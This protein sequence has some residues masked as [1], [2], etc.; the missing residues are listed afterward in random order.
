MQSCVSTPSI[1]LTAHEEE[2]VSVLLEAAQTAAAAESESS[3]SQKQSQSQVVVRI[4]GGWVRDKLLGYESDDID[5]ALENCTGEI[6]FHF[7]LFLF[8]ALTISCLPLYSNRN[9]IRQPCE[10][11]F[12]SVGLREA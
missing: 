9:R 11:H 1:V 7:Y 5:V 4:A 12:E 3:P 10:C 8:L 6:R 2:I